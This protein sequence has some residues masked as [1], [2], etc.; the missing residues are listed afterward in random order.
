MGGAATVSVFLTGLLFGVRTG[1]RATAAAR[2]AESI[3]NGDLDARVRPDGRDEITRLAASM[4]T[5]TDA[6]GARL[7]AERRATADIAHELRTPPAG[8]PTAA[9]LLPPGPCRT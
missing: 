4:N 9:G 7:E 6:L 8:M 2:T 5:M 1:R 3:A